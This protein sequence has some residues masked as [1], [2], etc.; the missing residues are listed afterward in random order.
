MINTPRR[1]GAASFTAERPTSSC[2][3]A[4]GSTRQLEW[5]HGWTNQQIAARADAKA[6]KAG[7]L[8]M[9]RPTE[10][11]GRGAA[12]WGLK[13]CRRSNPYILGT[14][15]FRNWQEGFDQAGAKPASPGNAR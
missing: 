10:A 11:C 14:R 7:A 5:L 9:S 2:Q 15:E 13:V 8:I 1:E 12:A 3:Y 6:D 4:A